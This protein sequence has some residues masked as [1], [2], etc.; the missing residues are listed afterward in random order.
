LL[1]EDVLC[2]ASIVGFGL[3]VTV[4]SNALPVQVPDV[5]VRLYVAVTAVYVLLV[6]VPVRDEPEPDV[7][8]DK[9]GSAAVRLQA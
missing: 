9:A 4:R 1:H 3:T 8:P 6:R 5:G 7:P 2:P